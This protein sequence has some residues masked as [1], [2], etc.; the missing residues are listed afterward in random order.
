MG[1]VRTCLVVTDVLGPP[2]ILVPRS[3]VR[4]LQGRPLVAG[5]LSAGCTPMMPGWG[6]HLRPQEGLDAGEHPATAAQ[7]RKSW[8]LRLQWR[9]ESRSWRHTSPGCSVYWDQACPLFLQLL[10][11]HPSKALRRLGEVGTYFLLST[12][13]LSS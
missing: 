6:A 4:R 3:G 8:K 2:T 12:S 11:K 10:V 9:K 1:A 13:L 5:P 7:C